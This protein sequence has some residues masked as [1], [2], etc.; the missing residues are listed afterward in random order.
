[1]FAN[2]TNKYNNVFQYVIF[3]YIN[4]YHR[5]I[6]GIPAKV[7]INSPKLMKIMKEKDKLANEKE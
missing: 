5:G 6:K 1:M 2:K 3:N 4:S 7:D